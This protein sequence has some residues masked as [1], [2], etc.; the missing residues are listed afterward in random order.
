MRKE[1]K[2]AITISIAVLVIVIVIISTFFIIKKH[3]KQN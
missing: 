2:K 1:I 3:K